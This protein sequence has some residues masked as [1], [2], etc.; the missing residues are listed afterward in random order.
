MEEW[1]QKL[2]DE[3]VKTTGGFYIC[4]NPL[5][6]RA[7]R[8]CKTKA[9]VIN[10]YRRSIHWCVGAQ[11]PS[12]E[13]LREYQS[14]Q[15]EN[16]LYI[17]HVFTGET[18]STQQAYIFHNCS[19]TVNVEMSYDRKRPNIPMLYFVQ[20]NDVTL[21]CNQDNKGYPIEIPLYVAEGNRV[22][23]TPSEGAI[24]KRSRLK[25]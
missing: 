17:D 4:N 2:I 5:Y 7:V 8:L 12:I 22:C 19:G 24:F 13:Y 16:G 1:K 21:T 11:F 9:D 18:I 25:W 6:E 20:D 15:Q 14:D 3:Y 10:L 23:V